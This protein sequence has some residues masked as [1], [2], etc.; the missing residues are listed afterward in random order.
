MQFNTLICLTVPIEYL[1]RAPQPLRGNF[2]AEVHRAAWGLWYL[3]LSVTRWITFIQTADYK[4]LGEMAHT[5]DEREEIQEYLKRDSRWISSYAH[6]CLAFLP[7][8]VGCK[9]L[10]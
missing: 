10:R 1:L 3:I 9:D 2:Q 7:M 4:E 5:L 6:S 8:E